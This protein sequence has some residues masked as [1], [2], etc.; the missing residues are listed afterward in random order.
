MIGN[1][2]GCVDGRVEKHIEQD[3]DVDALDIEDIDTF[4]PDI[5]LDTLLADFDIDS[6]Y[7][8]VDAN[9]SYLIVVDTVYNS[10][11]QYEGMKSFSTSVYQNIRYIQTRLAA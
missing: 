9:A 6:K 3:I 10:V 2:P 1:C 4:Q 7:I 5:D 8:D 11:Y